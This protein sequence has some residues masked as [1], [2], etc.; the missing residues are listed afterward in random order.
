MEAQV[1]DDGFKIS[2]PR[3]FLPKIVEATTTRPASRSHISLQQSVASGPLNQ[4]EFS[5]SARLN[6]KKRKRE[7]VLGES[8]EIE[9][10]EISDS[11][12]N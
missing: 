4:S 6:G 3:S 8:K 2:V 10:I 7:G 12:S 5:Q 1:L 9:M 11:D